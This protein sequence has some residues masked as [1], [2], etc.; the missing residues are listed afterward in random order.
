MLYY[1]LH[2]CIQP[3]ASLKVNGLFKIMLYK[4]WLIESLCYIY[5]LV[6]GL[7]ICLLIKWVHIIVTPTD[8]QGYKTYYVTK[9]KSNNELK[10]YT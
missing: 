9:I 8:V 2:I 3:H 5:F 10:Y 7:K 1:T 6:I 4:P